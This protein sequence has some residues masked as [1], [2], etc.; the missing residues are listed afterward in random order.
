MAQD[1][2]RAKELAEAH[3]G[4]IQKVLGTHDVSNSQIEKIK[5]HYITSFIH[6]YKHGVEDTEDKINENNNDSGGLIGIP[7]WN[8]EP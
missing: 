8:I 7:N 6:G 1:N 5:F 4:Y 3:W 2:N